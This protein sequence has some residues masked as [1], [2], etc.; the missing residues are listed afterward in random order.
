MVDETEKGWFVQYIDRDP[1]A[2]KKQEQI[3]AK[4]K[5]ELD[6]EERAAKFIKDQIE[7]ASAQG[8]EVKQTEFTELKRENEDEKGDIFVISIKNISLVFYY[9]K[10]VLGRHVVSL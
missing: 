8:Q 3:K 6:D 1:E 5:M 9:S 4:E 10:K 7:R 2:I